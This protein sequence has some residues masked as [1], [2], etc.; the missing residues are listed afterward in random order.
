M[1]DVQ[2]VDLL[3]KELAVMTRVAEEFARRDVEYRTLLM[4]LL[5]PNDLGHQVTKEVSSAVRGLVF[6]A[7]R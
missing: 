6:R 7:T 1:D 2:Q 5:D 3:A 4:R